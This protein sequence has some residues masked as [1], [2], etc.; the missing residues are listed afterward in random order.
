MSISLFQNIYN[1]FEIFHN[2]ICGSFDTE[3]A[4]FLT[5]AKGI[6]SATGKG[7]AISS[8]LD[9]WIPTL[10]SGDTYYNPHF[11]LIFENKGGKP[12]LIVEQPLSST[13]VVR[14]ASRFG[15]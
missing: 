9:H 12:V 8:I 5:V 14:L 10:M 3:K 4:Q 13:A 11:A 1:T 15:F 6:P 7:K 2:Q